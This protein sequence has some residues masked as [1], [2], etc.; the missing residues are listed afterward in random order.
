MSSF[1]HDIGGEAR[2]EVPAEY[3][4]EAMDTTYDFRYLLDVVE[5]IESEEVVFKLDTPV[6]AG[7]ITP[8][9][10]EAEG[11]DYQCLIMPFRTTEAES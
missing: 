9:R 11:E 3:E 10:E 1:S 7:I 4:G 2:E 8:S 6:S 5:R